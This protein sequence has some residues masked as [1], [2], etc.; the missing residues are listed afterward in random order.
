MTLVESRS[1]LKGLLEKD[2]AKRMTV[3]EILKHPWFKNLEKSMQ[4][5]NEQE[6]EKILNEFTY[7]DARR[8]GRNDTNAAADCF[9]LSPLTRRTTR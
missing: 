3:P 6:K 2:P 8:V 5:F 9:R 1:L 7:N 4:I